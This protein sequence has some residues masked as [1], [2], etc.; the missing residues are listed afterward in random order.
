MIN[1]L[2][3]FMSPCKDIDSNPPVTIP[4]E[5]RK[6][7]EEMGEPLVRATLAGPCLKREKDE[8][9]EERLLFEVCFPS[10]KGTWMPEAN[11]GN[12]GYPD[13]QMNCCWIGWA[14][15]WLRTPK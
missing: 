7:F 3:K 4:P 1:L 8:V 14:V 9:D 11:M 13:F 12:G 2:K 6:R 10:A 5:T 15:R